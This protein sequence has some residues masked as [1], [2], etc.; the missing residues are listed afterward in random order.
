MG[1][2]EDEFRP[3]FI[4]EAKG[5]LERIASGLLVLEAAPGDQAAIA[6]ILREAHTMKGA[7][8]MVGMTRVSHLAHRLEDLLVELR[9]GVRRSSPE[10]TDSMLQFVDGLG[11]LIAGT[12]ADQADISDD[13]ALASL[14]PVPIPVPSVVAEAGAAAPAP[15]VPI[16]STGPVS[17]PPSGALRAPPSPQVGKQ[18]SRLTLR[19]LGSLPCPLQSVFLPFLHARVARQQ[20][21][22]LQGGPEVRVVLDQ[23]SGDAV[24]D[25]SRLAARAATDDFDADVEFALGAGDAQG[26]QGS[27]LEDPASEV[28]E[29]VLVV[30][31][32]AALA[33]LDAD[34]GDGVLAPPSSS[35]K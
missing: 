34:A 26:R 17:T 11:R 33:R 14:L 16:P 25:R 19:V 32:D 4:E 7:S 20:A 3:L 9:A 13:A 5:H 21:G 15:A 30:D 35:M 12:A 6:G 24:G 29:R 10:L 28:G 8:G 18:T 2:L 31:E 23:R 1:E 22:L 27:H